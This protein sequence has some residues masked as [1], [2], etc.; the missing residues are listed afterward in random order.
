M[1]MVSAM[2]A[3]VLVAVAFSQREA[4]SALGGSS[5]VQ[6]V[7]VAQGIVARALALG[8]P[9]LIY[10]SA[11]S[12]N[13]I[14]TL[15]LNSS[16]S[17]RS[18]SPSM[19]SVVGT[20]AVGSVGDGGA[21]TSAELDLTTDLPYQR[22]AVALT[23]DGTMYIADSGNSTVRRIAGPAS[24]EPGIIRSV[25]GRWAAPQNVSLSKPI[26][27]ALDRAGDVYI[28][29]QG[30]GSLDVFRPES[31]LLETVAQVPTAASVVVT[32]DGTNAFVA[33]PST[34]KIFAVDVATHST[35][36]LDAVSAKDVSSGAPPCS[37]SS[38]RLCPAGLALDG[39]GNLFIAD[40]TF[41]RILR[42]DA[43]TGASSVVL[44][45]LQQPGAIAFDQQGRDLYVAEQGASRVVEAQGMGASA[46]PL[47][48]SPSSFTFPNEPMGGLSA[49]QQFTLFASAAV[50]GLQ[51]ASPLAS[52]AHG[53]F[54]LQGTSCGATLAAGASCFINVAFTPTSASAAQFTPVSSSLTVTDSNSDSV[55]STLTGTAD[56][57]QIQLASGQPLEVSV[58]QGN[59]VTFHLQVA[60]L[61]A[62]GQNGEQVSI[63]CPSGTPAQTTC[64]AKPSTVSPTPGSPAAF[65]ITL[66]TSN[67][68][69]QAKLMPM[70]PAPPEY[71]LS[72]P[73]LLFSALGLISI[74]L[75]VTLRGRVR[76][77]SVSV[78]ALSA[79]MF[80]NGC[81]SASTKASA[82]PAGAA[83]ILV[84]G[85][86]ITQSGAPFN[87]T[88]G[89]TVTL[90]VLK[91]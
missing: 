45:G 16:S 21:A 84:Q 58:F 68:V 32:P 60:A 4:T 85:A 90:D 27:L 42:V 57:Y 39:G 70:S 69:T 37:P 35:R 53:D 30:A 8:P 49:Q 62:F 63:I 55:S 71:P 61:G 25:A 67:T 72:G 20:G 44:S 52:S 81:H 38:N 19:V 9:G 77:V 50:S 47:Q 13:R 91:D 10:V 1:L 43:G 73:F 64:T 66:Q 24:S 36:T 11:A 26:G 51:I 31:G 6:P 40:S 28:T 12:S 46:G 41:G 34:G 54:S 87:A 59:A 82:T 83:Q 88:R 22:S 23:S 7:V 74:P 79:A 29:D 65:T 78:L 18:P 48:L 5:A 3:F 2:A 75:L 33:S 80:L 76:Y 14:F 17:L 86:A 15:K 56:D 89:L